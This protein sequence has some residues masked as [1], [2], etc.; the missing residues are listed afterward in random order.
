M[1][2]RFVDIHHHLAYGMDDGPKSLK[3]MKQMLK[4]AA[5]EGIGVI[6]ATPH[7]TPGVQRFHLEEYHQ[8]LADARAYCAEKGL[9]IEIREGCEILYTDQSPR[10]LS[11]G[12]I[13]TLCGTDYVLVEFS[14]DIKYSKLRE[15]LDRLL[16]EGYRPVVAHVERYMCLTNRPSRAEKLKEELDVKFQ[17][18]CASIIKNKGLLTRRFIKR[19]LEQQM[20]DALGTDAHNVSSRAAN[21]KEAYKIIKKKYG[22]KYARK[23]TSGSFLAE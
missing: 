7:A 19:M 18:N 3:Q 15:A 20:I 12:R 13:P 11:E 2:H 22:G 4:H 23:L 5:A 6:I 8:A 21:M 16:I 17:V 9:E 10:L 1:K 14:P